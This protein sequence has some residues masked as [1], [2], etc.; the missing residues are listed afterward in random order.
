MEGKK[1]NYSV[2]FKVLICTRNFSTVANKFQMHNTQH[3]FLYKSS[4]FS[5]S[6]PMSLN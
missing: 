1:L 6:F 5:A 2:H 3:I 4:F